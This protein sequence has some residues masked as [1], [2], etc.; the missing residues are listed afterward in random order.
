MRS[1]AARARRLAVFRASVRQLR[2]VRATGRW[3]VPPAHPTHDR[4]LASVGHML[5]KRAASADFSSR[6]SQ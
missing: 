3:P 5:H 1:P 2:G 6:L 4:I